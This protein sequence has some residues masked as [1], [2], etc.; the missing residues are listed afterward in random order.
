MQPMNYTI[1][2]KQPFANALS[3]V[4]A[5]FGLSNA[6]DKAQ[7]Q[8]LALQ[9]QVEMK[10]DLGVLAQ[11]P[12]PTAQDFA[13]ITT[14]YPQLAEHFKNTWSMLNT[15]QQQNRLGQATQVYS[16]LQSGKVD[17]AKK[18]LTDQATA[19]RNAGQ[20]NDAKAAE[21]MLQLVDSKPEI[22]LNSA[23]LMLSSILGPDKF[24]TTFSTLSKLPSEVRKGTADATK[25]EYE[26]NNTP[27]RLDLENRYKGA[28]IRNLDSQISNRAGQLSLDRDKLQSE[29][30]L[31]LY[32]LNQKNTQLD[33]DGRKLVNDSV[34]SSVAADQA[35]GQMVDLANRLD[36]TPA[37]YGGFS[38]ASE[39]LKKQTGNQDY[40]TQMRNEYTRI[41][42]SQVMKFLPPGSASD[43]DIAFA[44]AGFPPDNADTKTMASFLRG[45]AK[46]N[47]LSAVSE[48]AKAEWVNAVGHL[49]KPKQD[50]NI[51]GVNVPAGS[52]FTDFARQYLATKAEQRGAQQAQQNVGS[53]SYMRWANPQGQQ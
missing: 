26:A 30:E 1:D 16:A 4:E 31:R 39:W 32:E 29:T 36:K 33:G 38:T 17:I 42:N 6:M 27:E 5:G 49:G 44:V 18:L 15:D 19:F 46:L 47:Q 50:I 9:Q 25:A 22:A 21:T 35:A 20:E 23:G 11:N 51:D 41:R 12:N 8:Q 40:M 3:G 53:R 34:V 14:K 13:Q 43:K 52:T 24:S 48:N 10:R 7:Q 28:E 45:M 2:V 37:G